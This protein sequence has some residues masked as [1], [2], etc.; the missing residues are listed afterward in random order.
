MTTKVVEES[1]RSFD[2]SID[3]YKQGLTPF[4]NVVDAQMNLLSYSNSR[5]T[6]QGRALSALIDLYRALGG[7]FQTELDEIH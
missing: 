3:L 4:S 5:V 1:Q 2:L 7:G 6:A